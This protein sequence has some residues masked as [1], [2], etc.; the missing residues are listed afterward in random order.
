M[1]LLKF[2]HKVVNTKWKQRIVEC[3]AFYQQRTIKGKQQQQQQ[4]QKEP[5]INAVYMK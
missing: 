4:Q 1:Q 3:I 5:M 2:L